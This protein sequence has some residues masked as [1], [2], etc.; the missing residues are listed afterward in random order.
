MLSQGS[1]PPPPPLFLARLP[2]SLEPGKVWRGELIITAFDRYW[3]L[4]PWEKADPV[5]VPVPKP[6]VPSTKH[7]ASWL[8][9]ADD[10]SQWEVQ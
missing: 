6:D 10:G 5:T 2:C 4:P 1:P 8:D 7:N 9:V 3:D